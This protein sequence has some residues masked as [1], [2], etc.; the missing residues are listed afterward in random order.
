[1]KIFFSTNYT[2]LHQNPELVS[3]GMVDENGREFYCEANDYVNSEEIQKLVEDFIKPYNIVYFFG[4]HIYFDWI[5]LR[6]IWW[7]EWDIPK[8]IY[9]IP[10]DLCSLFLAEGIDPATDCEYFAGVIIKPKTSTALWD[11]KVI[12][13]CYFRIMPV[14]SD[15]KMLFNIN[16]N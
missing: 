9:D 10:F 11:A 1:M 2:G 13:E 6:R 16:L 8:N 4:K 3:I 7:R 14:E 15:D 5:L 12:K